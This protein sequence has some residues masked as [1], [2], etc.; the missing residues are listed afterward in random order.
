MG[1]LKKLV[2]HTD[3]NCDN[4]LSEIIATYGLTPDTTMI[5][6]VEQG[7][8]SRNWIIGNK[9]LRYFLKRY[10]KFAEERVREIHATM[11]YFSNHDIPI[12]M[13]LK[14]K[15]GLDY[16]R[17]EDGNSYA[18]FPFVSG[19]QFERRKMP[20]DAIVAM[21][22]TLA[23]IH[24]LSLTDPI[25]VNDVVGDWDNQDFLSQAE[26]IMNIISAKNQLNE[27][28]SL[29][30]GKINKQINLVKKCNQKF[31]DLSLRKDTL[32]HGDYQEGNVFFATDNSVE[33]V[34]DLEKCDMEPRI[35]EVLRVIDLMIIGGKYS[36]DRLE[37]AKVFLRAYHYANP[38]AS[39]EII[40][41]CLARQTKEAH[42]LWIEEEYYLR[43]NKRPMIY[44][45]DRVSS[46]ENRPENF[47]QILTNCL[48]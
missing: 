30:K 20:D 18:L 45:A 17:D 35:Y 40:D 28:D 14:Q 48:K 36:V 4:L 12:I 29:V 34:F 11:E 44:M 1:I 32:C 6:A 25:V 38:L 8:L 9:K 3:V 27:F 21:A 16:W 22:E 10:R 31:S 46:L 39:Q 2:S 7:V 33:W 41:G 13:P 15:N 24:R 47:A 26:K 5:S 19:K 43:E 23:Q 42:S 37:E